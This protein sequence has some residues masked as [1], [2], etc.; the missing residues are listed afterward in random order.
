M[1]HKSSKLNVKAM[2]VCQEDPSVY[3]QLVTEVLCG[4][5]CHR[6]MRMDGDEQRF[7]F[8]G[9]GE[10]ALWQG[11]AALCQRGLLISLPTR[12]HRHTLYPNSL[13]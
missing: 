5:V 9:G 12:T 4:C 7:F 1:M 3:Q 13:T 2:W 8:L 10:I 6:V 11:N